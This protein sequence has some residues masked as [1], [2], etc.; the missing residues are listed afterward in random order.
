M[1]TKEQI[2]NSIMQKENI[3]KSFRLDEKDHKTRL[4]L[5]LKNI[6]KF[7]I[8]DENRDVINKLYNY[9]TGNEKYCVENN[10][11][12]GKGIMLVGTVGSGK[13]ILMR[14]LKQYTSTVL[15]YNSYQIHLSSEIIDN[16]NVQGVN[17]LIRFGDAVGKPITCY[18]DDICSKNEIVKNY[19]TEIKVIEQLVSIRYNIYQK[20]SLLTHFS[21][22]VYPE[23]MKDYYDNRTI[24]RLKEMCNVIELKG[25]SRRK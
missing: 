12:L 24:D 20:Y 25:E 11:S 1:I 22:N 9:F 17:Y 4:L 10:I 23:N 15:H 5:S 14:G 19:G 8:D 18:I 13:S 21:T 3:I 6:S 16:V 2:Q 7:I